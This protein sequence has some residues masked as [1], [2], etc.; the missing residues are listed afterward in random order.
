MPD[1]EE[2]LIFGSLALYV[3]PPL[4]LP[5]SR[6]PLSHSFKLLL[7]STVATIFTWLEQPSQHLRWPTQTLARRNRA[8]RPP[9]VTRR[10]RRQN[11]RTLEL[12][13]LSNNRLAKQRADGQESRPNPWQCRRSVDRG[14]QIA[15]V[16]RR[17]SWPFARC[18]V[19]EAPPRKKPSVSPFGW[20]TDMHLR[21]RSWARRTMRQTQAVAL[22]RARVILP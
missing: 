8:R 10:L 16:G 21:P 20:S 19:R 6:S 13:A 7:L 17:L 15:P 3:C 18:F 22:P 14:M 9:R 1:K 4:C 11:E 5:V 2:S 12:C